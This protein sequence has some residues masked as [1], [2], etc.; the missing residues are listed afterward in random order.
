[1]KLIKLIFVTSFLALSAC[2]IEAGGKKIAEVGGGG[3]N[4]KTESYSY[5]YVENGCDTGKI[6][7]GSQQER[8]DKLRDD[9]SNQYC[10]R[11]MHFEAFKAE[12]PGQKW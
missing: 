7:A 5:Q 6:T 2:S 8:C 9:A 12:C 10:A 4:K 11:S 3:D 1:M